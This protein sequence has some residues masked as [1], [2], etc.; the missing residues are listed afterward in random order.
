[1]SSDRMTGYSDATNAKSLIVFNTSVSGNFTPEHTTSGASLP[2]YRS[3][4]QTIRTLPTTIR[5]KLD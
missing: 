3:T 4:G 2:S 5:T 1:M